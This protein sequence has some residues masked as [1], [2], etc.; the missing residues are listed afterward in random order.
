MI[1]FG[2]WQVHKCWQYWAV[3]IWDISA[4]TEGTKK[5]LCGENTGENILRET[6]NTNSVQ[7][8]VESDTMC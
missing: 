7:S 2:P 5:T 3:V 6:E 4:K 8:E 1:F